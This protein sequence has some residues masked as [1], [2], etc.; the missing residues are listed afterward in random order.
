M[1]ETTEKITVSNTET[2]VVDAT[3]GQTV[4]VDIENTSVVIANGGFVGPP[5]SA[6]IGT[7]DDVD[8]SNLSDGSLLIYNAQTYKWTASSLLDKQALECGQY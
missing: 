6:K 5:G 1:T 2:I 3:S 7:A 4:S 8:A